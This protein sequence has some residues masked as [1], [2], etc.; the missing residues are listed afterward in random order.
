MNTP[1]APDSHTKVYPLQLRFQKRVLP[2][3]LICTVM[4]VTAIAWGGR[5][6]IIGVYLD[7]AGRDAH[8]LIDSLIREG[9]D[10]TQ[11]WFAI[12]D[13]PVGSA[14]SANLRAE[15]W[16]RVKASLAAMVQ[17]RALPKLKIYDMQGVVRYSSDPTGIGLVERTE[18][19]DQIL[20]TRRP[21]AFRVVAADGPQFELYTFLP[22]DATEPPMIVEVYEPSDFLDHALLK[23]LLPAALLPA[24]VLIAIMLVLQRMVRT[25]QGQLDTQRENVEALQF[26]LE[27]L[28]SNRAASAARDGSPALTSGH[29]TDVTL[30]FSDVRDF[31]SYAET[32]R[33]EQ[34]VELLNHLISIQVEVIDRMGGDVDKIIGDAVLAVFTGSDRA[35]KAIACAQEVLTRCSAQQELPRKLAIG[36]HDGVVVA[37]AIGAA[38]RQDY[39]VIGDA[40]NVSQRLCTL[41]KVNQLVSDIHTLQRA[42][43]PDAF[44]EVEEQT[45]KGRQEAIR[46]RRWEASIS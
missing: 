7:R 46:V 27:K 20:R 24:I 29:V 3:L 11:A 35:A 32:H 22:G 18:G 40:V 15:D 37:G 42:G 34:V 14:A 21:A 2:W 12:F 36:V 43:H 19:L 33:P 4:L 38:D 45:V 26:R 28:V 39:T 41:A 17:D 13:K 9:E 31:T 44:G 6:L 5:H 23:T 1:T 16:A 8:A 10:S 25:A 30:Y